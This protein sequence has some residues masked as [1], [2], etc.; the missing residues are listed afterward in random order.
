MIDSVLGAAKKPIQNMLKGK[1]AQLKKALKLLESGKKSGGFL[2]FGGKTQTYGQNDR[3]TF[4]NDSGIGD[5]AIAGAIF[6]IAMKAVSM[7]QTP[8]SPFMDWSNKSD[9]ALEE[10]IA[11]QVSEVRKGQSEFYLI[12]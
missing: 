12:D 6:D 2:G 5:R 9:E 4:I 8:T 3:D 1:G 11:S 7:G 10:L